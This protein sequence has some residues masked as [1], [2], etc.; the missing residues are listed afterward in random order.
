MNPL[1]P[2]QLH[3]PRALDEALE[4]LARYGSDARL[5]AGGTD[6]VVNLR[7]GLEAPAHV[8]SLGS[9]A[10]LRQARRDPAGAL[11]LGALIRLDEL[12]RSE[13]VRREYPVLSSAAGTVSGPTLRGMGTLGGNVC[14]DTRCQWYN[15]SFPWRRGCGFGL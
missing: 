6:L 5:L 11:R 10:E 14:L 12:I 1:P 7:H 13:D 4:L 2:F 15:Q 8:V 9:I 3:R